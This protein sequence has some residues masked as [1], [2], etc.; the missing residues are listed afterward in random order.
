MSNSPSPHTELLAEP[1]PGEPLKIAAG[2]LAQAWKERQQPNPDAM[3]LATATPDGAPSA[4]VVLCKQ[5]V[6]PPGYVQ[7]Y[8]NYL[9]RKG[10]ELGENPRAAIVMHWDH[11]HRQVRVEGHIVKAPEADSDAYFASR[12]LAS[13]VGAWASQQSQPVESRQKLLDAVAA[14]SKRFGVEDEAES[15]R[16]LLVRVEKAPVVS[17]PVVPRPPHW[18]GY[19]LWAEAVELWVEGEHRIHD[20]ARWTRTLTPKGAGDFEFGPWAATRLQP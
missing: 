6:A 16:R 20:R 9:S 17:E 15:H 19:R 3:V 18:G 7:F 4:R 5:I 12:A 11:L 14:A 13:R 10:H 1:L 8:T 2:W